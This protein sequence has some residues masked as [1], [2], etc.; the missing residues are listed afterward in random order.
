M[1]NFSFYKPSIFIPL[2]S[3]YRT[4]NPKTPKNK[5]S[6]QLSSS[7][8]CLSF[9]LQVSHQTHPRQNDQPKSMRVWSC[10]S[11]MCSNQCTLVSWGLFC[12]FRSFMLRHVWR[13]FQ[14]YCRNAC[15]RGMAFRPVSRALK[16]KSSVYLFLNVPTYLIHCFL[17]LVANSDVSTFM[18]FF[19]TFTFYPQ[20]L[21]LLAVVLVLPSFLSA[22]NVQYISYQ[23]AV[24]IIYIDSPPNPAPSFP[25]PSPSSPDI[26]P[27]Q[28]SVPF[29]LAKPPNCPANTISC[30]SIGEPSWC[31]TTAQ[32]CAFDEGEDIACC[33]TGDFC[34]GRVD[35]DLV[36][37]DGGG[38]GGRPGGGDGGYTQPPSNGNIPGIQYGPVSITNSAAD[39][40]ES[41]LCRTLRLGLLFISGAAW[42]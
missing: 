36:N 19:L 25:S 9:H 35:Y 12:S 20:M 8:S 5:K 3:S 31:C 1:I 22:S 17:H 26:S 18:S 2:L 32:H 7:I 28:S 6:L 21:F 4:L 24:M 39:R 23:P 11:K 41:S 14:T 10:A 29:S 33:P 27:Q 15:V 34:R 30:D 40:S 16:R 38:G 42:V 37:G 13:I